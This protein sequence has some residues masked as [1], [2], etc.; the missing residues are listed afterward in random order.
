[1]KKFFEDID[2]DEEISAFE[3]HLAEKDAHRFSQK[4]LRKEKRGRKH[5]SPTLNMRIGKGSSAF[6][7]KMSHKLAR[8]SAEQ[9]KYNRTRYSL[10]QREFDMT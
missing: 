6:C 2:V 1:M 5:A 10:K 4:S 7:K 9:C 3:D 8:R